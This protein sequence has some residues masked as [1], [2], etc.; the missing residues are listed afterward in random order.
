MGGINFPSR[1]SSEGRGPGRADR[2]PDRPDPPALCSIPG[3]SGP[4]RL[5]GLT[6]P[7]P[8]SLRRLWV[9]FPARDNQRREKGPTDQPR[10]VASIDR[11]QD[12][13]LLELST[14][15]AK[16]SEGSSNRGD[17]DVQRTHETVTS[18]ST[19]QLEVV[20]RLKNKETGARVWRPEAP[21]TTRRLADEWRVRSC[22][23]PPHS[24]SVTQ[25][26]PPPPHPRHRS[27][28][29]ALRARSP[30]SARPAAPYPAVCPPSWPSSAPAR[31][32]R[33]AP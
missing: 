11:F 10:S 14:V 31:S 19:N 33:A 26:S 7:R 9:W 29:R 27:S 15:S 4:W 30:P 3:W 23:C 1:L 20:Y 25:W 8:V 17:D 2:A 13:P 6:S 18:L 28:P 32:S 5:R 24:S 12:C 16:F 22:V 21:P